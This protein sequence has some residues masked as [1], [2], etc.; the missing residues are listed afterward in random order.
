V[1]G[2]YQPFYPTFTSLAPEASGDFSIIGKDFSVVYPRQS[3]IGG[4]PSGASSDLYSR[5]IAA[6]PDAG[7]AVRLL[8]Q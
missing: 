7:T 2:S 6:N 8:L 5:K 1:S 3:F 4:A